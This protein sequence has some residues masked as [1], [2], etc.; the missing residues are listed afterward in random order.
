MSKI[1]QFSYSGVFDGHKQSEL[2]GVCH[3]CDAN[4]GTEQGANTGKTKAKAIPAI[5][6]KKS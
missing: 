2:I 4:L 1:I 3:K 6:A 5:I